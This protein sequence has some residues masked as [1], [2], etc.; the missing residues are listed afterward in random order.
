MP[1]HSTLAKKRILI[2]HDDGNSFNNPTVK[3]IIDLLLE[4]GDEIDLR[5]PHSDAPMPE[6]GGIRLLPFGRLTKKIKSIVYN[7]ICL[8]AFIYIM[9]IIEKI[10]VYKKYDLIIGIDRQGLLEA[11]VLNDI[12]DTPF[13]YISFEISFEDETS[14]KF[15]SIE[16]TA[17]KAVSGWLVQD[18]IRAEL[19]QNENQLDISTQFLLPLASAGQGNT[20]THRLRDSLGIPIDKKVAIVIGTVSKWA[21]TNKLLHCA[22]D[23]PENWVLIFH[24]RYGRTSKRLSGEL[25]SIS[26][27]INKKIYISDAATD[28]VD[29]MGSILQGISAGLAFYEPEFTGNIADRFIGKNLK[30]L[31]L[32]AGKISTY[33]RYG[34][35]VIMN[36][37]GLYAEEA[38]QFKF[39]CVAETPKQIK[40]C[41]ENMDTE[42]CRINAK[43]YFA[44]KLDFNIYKEN[45]YSSFLSQH[46]SPI[47]ESASNHKETSS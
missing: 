2:I 43:D 4:K 17:S 15:K 9:V 5:Y 33:L 25:A 41:L 44:L 47:G 18:E 42:R 14:Q 32:A 1:N 11:K 39:G 20:S 26:H 29:D 37:V 38:R 27:L 19:L 34:V 12:T 24:D 28:L 45:V 10:F 31:G 40:N 23:W 46:K 3:C 35:P 36:D 6:Y 8:W 16:K 21:M 22:A 13:V 7:R 30:Y